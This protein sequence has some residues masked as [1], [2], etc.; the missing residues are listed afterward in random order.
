MTS[1]SKTS[2]GKKR[3]T[4]DNNPN[5][6][7]VT[8]DH[9]EVVTRVPSL[10]KIVAFKED[11]ADSYLTV[12]YPFVS[13]NSK[14]LHLRVKPF[15]LQLQKS[16][17][18][19]SFD[20]PPIPMTDVFCPSVFHGYQYLHY[21]I[22]FPELEKFAKNCLKQESPE[23]IAMQF[24]PDVLLR[25]F[26]SL[27]LSQFMGKDSNKKIKQ[28]IQSR[29]SDF[30][31]KAEFEPGSPFHI[32]SHLQTA[33]FLQNPDL[34]ELLLVGDETTNECKESIVSKS[35]MFQM[36]GNNGYWAQK[37]ANGNILTNVRDLLRMLK[38]GNVSKKSS[39]ILIQEK[40]PPESSMLALLAAVSQS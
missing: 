12:Y 10:P 38:Q 29:L 31:Q 13:T 24:H 21:L 3:K 11:S 20:A 19:L 27:K 18:T 1:T 30:L 40:K 9:K 25:R 39:E 2:K 5:N 33:K 15:Q 17:I 36:C 7:S 35:V 37:N 14:E 28:L 8:T 16:S 32:M 22:S 23:T 4:M 34:A 26:Q 6:H